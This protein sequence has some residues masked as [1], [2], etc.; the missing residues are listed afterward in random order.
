[1]NMQVLSWDLTP[2]KQTAAC[3]DWSKMF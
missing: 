3:S 2:A 1:M